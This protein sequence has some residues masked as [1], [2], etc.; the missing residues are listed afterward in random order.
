MLVAE[1]LRGRR[2]VGR[3]D[4]GAEL[5]DGLLDACRRRGVRAGEI[6]VVGS[7]EEAEVTNLGA[8]GRPGHD[9][10]RR[11]AG[12]LT[13]VHLAGHLAEREGR[14]HF[15]AGCALSREGDNGVSDVRPA[16]A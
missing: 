2:L 14:L 8:H 10:A 15:E 11:F 16:A 12:P 7:V 3:I 6:R 13:I 4:R 9:P 1:S 5:V